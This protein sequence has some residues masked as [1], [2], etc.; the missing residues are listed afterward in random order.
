MG[1]KNKGSKGKGKNGGNHN[2]HNSHNHSSYRQ[3]EEG[4]GCFYDTVGEPTEEMMIKSSGPD[5]ILYPEYPLDPGNLSNKLRGAVG[6]N[7]MFELTQIMLAQ[8]VWKL[9]TKDDYDEYLFGA[10]TNTLLSVF[11]MNIAASLNPEPP[12]EREELM[13]ARLVELE[14]RVTKVQQVSKV[15]E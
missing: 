13:N 11:D 15:I 2:N 9:W 3:S 10:H 4:A 12:Q 6:H 5:M 1:R 8:R 7:K 14:R